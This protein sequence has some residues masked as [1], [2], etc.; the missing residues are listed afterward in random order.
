[1]IGSTG[2]SGAAAAGALIQALD[3]PQAIVRCRVAQALVGVGRTGPGV[4]ALVESLRDPSEEAREWAGWA[5]AWDD[6][7]AAK[8][9]AAHTGALIAALDDEDTFVREGAMGALA[10]LGPEAA[11][12]VPKLVAMLDHPSSE[13]C[14]AAAE[15][16]AAIGAPARGALPALKPLLDDERPQVRAAAGRAV[17]ALGDEEAGLAALYDVLGGGDDEAI[18]HALTLVDSAEVARG[19]APQLANVVWADDPYIACL[20]AGALAR[21][22]DADG[23]L[24]PLQSALASEEYG[25][26]EAAAKGLGL[27]GEKGG[28]AVPALTKA[29]D[30]P[31]HRVRQAAVEALGKIG[32]PAKSALP[33]V[34]ELTD[35]PRPEVAEAARAAVEAIEAAR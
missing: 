3:D 15:A 8:D 25:V 35:D 2:D 19:V 11:P 27:L 14:A 30:D 13:A 33:R 5:L 9:L 22:G 29:L 7:V 17:F 16:L 1:V 34:R 26:R 10:K 4:A 21:A 32:A 6:R 20:A 31:W 28:D 12:A 18:W 24:G 23:A